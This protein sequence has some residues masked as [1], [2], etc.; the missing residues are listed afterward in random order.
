MSLGRLKEINDQR[1]EQ[2]L[3]SIRHQEGIAHT[4][5]VSNTILTTTEALIKYLQ[6]AVSKVELTNQLQSISTP[7]VEHVVK[8][9]GILDQTIKNT[10]QT[11]LSGII[12]LMQEL[13]DEAK[14]IPKSLPEIP[15]PDKPVDYTEQF[16]GLAD[17]IKA[18]EKVVKAQKLVAEA[19]VVNVPAPNVK[20]DAPNLVPLQNGFRDVVK[21][22]K[23]IVI[24]EYKTDNKAVE[25]LLKDSNKLLKKI[26]EK[27]VSSGGGGGG[28][29]S[30]YQ[31]ASGI[32]AFVTLG[33]A[34]AAT[35][36]P[37]VLTAAQLS[38]LTPTG[39]KARGSASAVTQVASSAT[40]VTLKAANVNRIKLVIANDSTAVLYVKEGASAS[41]TSYSYRLAQNE[42]VIID[43]YTGIVDGLW[44]SANGFAYV[45]ET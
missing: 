7:D 20:V 33:Q 1:A 45:T 23:A 28:R 29:V 12:Q 14:L 3:G 27:P 4:D 34:L 16:K 6:G 41:A 13:V 5:N 30:P 19:P 42:S 25:K 36:L 11:D 15:E 18:V 26:V 17:A 32:P 31:D 43:D 37:V 40:N 39:L 44:A 10:P 22:V 21:A 2:E 35:S 24:P 38:T 8:A 9:L